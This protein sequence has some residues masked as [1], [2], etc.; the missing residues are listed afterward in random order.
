[1]VLPGRIAV[2]APLSEEVFFRYLASRIGWLDGVV[3]C[4]G[5]PTIHGDLPAFIERIRSLGF[6]VKL[7]TNGSRPEV[8]RSLLAAGLLDYVAM[9]I[10]HPWDRYDTI[11]G[12]DGMGER[13]RETASLLMASGIA[14]EFRTTVARGVHSTE[15]IRMIAES[16]HGARA[17]CLQNFEQREVLDPAFCGERFTHAEMEMLCETARAYVPCE[18][19]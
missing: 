18:L 16:I 11:V 2:T 13:A 9:D 1:M 5:E 4:G 8:V 10:K 6:L 19:R 7:D 12:V 17:Y 15:D 14:Y 3:I